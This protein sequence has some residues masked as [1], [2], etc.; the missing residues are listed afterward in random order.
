MSDPREPR[1]LPPEFDPR[2]GQGPRAGSRGPDPRGGS[3]GADSRGGYPGGSPG[4]GNRGGPG[5]SRDHPAGN[6]GLPPDLDP[7]GRQAG[8]YSP[9]GLSGYDVPGGRPPGGPGNRPPAGPGN[10]PPGGPGGRPSTGDPRRGNPVLRAARFA[11]AFLSV[12]VLVASGVMWFLYRDFTTKVDRVNAIGAT[13]GD[14]DGKDQNILLVGSDD[15][16]NATPAELAELSTT[17]AITNSTD[18]MILVHIPADGRKATAVSFPRDSWVPIPG[19]GEHKLNSAYVNGST[20]C[21]TAKADPDRG[22]QKLV[23]TISE[24]SGVKI[25]HYVEV[26]LLG[27]YRITRAIGGVQVCLNAAQ[28]DS[29]SGIDLPKG[30]ST[31]EGKQAV[32][33]IRQRHGLPRGDLDRIVR[34]QYFMSAVFRK[35]TSLGTLTNPIKLKRL[36]DA[37]GTSLRMD[38]SLDPLQL[39]GQLRGLAAGNVTF[40]TIPTQGLGTRSG[41]SVVLVDDAAIKSFFTTVINPPKPKTPVTAAARSGTTVAVF[42][43]SG[44]S[45]LAATASTALVKAGFKASSAGN[46]D[47]QDYSRTEIRYGA[48]GEA[49]ARAVLAAIP[50][51]KLVQRSGVDGVQLVLGSDFTTL[52]AR[53]TPKAS[54]SPKAAGDSRTAADAGCVN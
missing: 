25:D 15:R 17:D 35:V 10:R 42:N 2:R 6:R 5:G 8:A 3:R 26:D 29:F 44:R 28:K 51:A 45:G 16:T 18:T 21:G 32:A 38:D 11:A 47:R 48:D 46:A 27:F 43:G 1:G 22:R 12:L 49:Q 7:R 54:S 50:T 41:Q 31:I 40:T 24:L 20:D 30:T 53:T 33:F 37:I 9:E 13:S 19:C 14:V 39:A 23:Q 4:G 34:Q 36:L 52:G